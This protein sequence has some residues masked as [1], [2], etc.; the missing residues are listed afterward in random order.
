MCYMK[1]LTMS[2]GDVQTNLR[3]PPEL[4]KWLQQQAT[5]ARRSLSAEVAFRLESTRDDQREA[6]KGNEK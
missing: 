6:Q 1:D 2:Q 3:L 5:K 4:K